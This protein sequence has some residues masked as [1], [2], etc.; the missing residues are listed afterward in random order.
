MRSSF[1]SVESHSSRFT[2]GT[3][4]LRFRNAAYVRYQAPSPISAKRVCSQG[5]RSRITATSVRG[6]RTT[7]LPRQAA[8][9]TTSVRKAASRMIGSR[10]YVG[11]ATPSGS[12][13]GRW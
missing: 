10:T 2:N 13:S 4:L 8:R 11:T 6:K 3:K 7:D 12:R 9:G 1:S 5:H